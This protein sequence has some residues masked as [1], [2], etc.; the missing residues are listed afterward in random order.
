MKPWD[1][2]RLTLDQFER[3]IAWIDDY[4]RQQEAQARE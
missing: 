2:E 3:A 1:V 4:Q